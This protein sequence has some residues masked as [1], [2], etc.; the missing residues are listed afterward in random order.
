M[1]MRTR[2]KEA[3]RG[4]LR[5]QRFALARSRRERGDLHSSSIH[6]RVNHV[7]N[8]RKN[9]EIMAGEIRR[10]IARARARPLFIR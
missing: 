10:R 9:R 2:A 7:A 1:E 3:T 5:V 6:Q 4:F 8:Y